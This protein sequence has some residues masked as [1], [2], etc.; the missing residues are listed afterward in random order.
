MG[1]TALGGDQIGDVWHCSTKHYRVRSGEPGDGL[2]GRLREATYSLHIQAERS[3][4]IRDLLRG[5]ASRHG[6][7]L[8]LRNLMPAYARLEEGLERHRLAA[9][10]ARVRAGGLPRDALAADLGSSAAPTGAARCRCCQPASAMPGR[11]SRRGGDGARLI[12][13][14][15]TRYL[16]D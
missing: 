16:G 10:R 5:Q 3:G 9:R 4:V 2:V 15:Y 12:A 14:A 8:L 1:G 11:S 13:H 6:Y 7:A